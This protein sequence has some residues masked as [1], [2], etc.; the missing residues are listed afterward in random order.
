ME[1]TMASSFAFSGFLGVL[2]LLVGG[3]IVL[4]TC[5]ACIL[6]VIFL[7]AMVANWIQRWMQRKRILEDTNAQ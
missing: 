4:L 3:G 6:F 2:F 1:D 7:V 5:G